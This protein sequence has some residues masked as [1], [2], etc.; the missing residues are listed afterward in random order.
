[1]S[2]L[3]KSFIVKTVDD[4][5][6]KWRKNCKQLYWLSVWYQ[7]VDV[8][9]VE[10]DKTKENLARLWSFL[11]WRLI[12]SH[13]RLIDCLMTE[14]F[15]SETIEVFSAIYRNKEWNYSCNQADK[16]KPFNHV[17]M[18]RG[19]NDLPWLYFCFLTRIK[20]GILI[21]YQVIN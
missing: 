19:D 16:K 1:M 17:F 12:E 13:L 2:S 18:V 4:E 11:E 3:V 5:E 6:N 10:F 9:T 21:V 15:L 8:I 7:D 20:S 14:I